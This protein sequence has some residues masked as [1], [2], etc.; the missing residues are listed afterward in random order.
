MKK[1]IYTLQQSRIFRES[2]IIQIDPQNLWEIKRALSKTFRHYCP[3][4]LF[5]FLS[6]G[7]KVSTGMLKN[8]LCKSI[9]VKNFLQLGQMLVVYEGEEQQGVGE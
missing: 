3:G 6:E 1:I 4:E 7:Q 9:T 5:C 8:S 2:Y